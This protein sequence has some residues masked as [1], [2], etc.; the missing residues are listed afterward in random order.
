[1]YIETNEKIIKKKEYLGR[2]DLTEVIVPYGVE[3]IENWAFAQCK[4][5][6][7]IAIPKT[8]KKMAKDIFLDSDNLTQIYFFDGKIADRENMF[9]SFSVGKAC[10]AGMT[11]IAFVLFDDNELKNIDSIGTK[12]WFDRWDKNCLSYIN[13][14]DGKDFSPF[15]SGGEE[16][17]VDKENNY[18][19][20]CH[21]KRVKNVNIIFNRLIGN[22]YYP[23]EEENKNAFVKYLENHIYVDESQEKEYS[24]EACKILVET[25]YD[26]NEVF[27]IYDENNLITD[28]NIDMIIKNVPDENIELK[29]LLLRKKNSEK[30]EDVWDRF[31]L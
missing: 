28:A 5:L 12:A 30:K 7:R 14:E 1:M 11:A 3:E 6:N 13:Q 22:R 29:A 21:K 9:E 8:V 18:E 15:L 16:D 4:N 31:S 19:Y 2:N 27:E 25:K 24:G 26:A 20:F 10:I 17:Y 23:L